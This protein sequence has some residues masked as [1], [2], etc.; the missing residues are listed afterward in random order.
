M[1]WLLVILAAI[2]GFA[3]IYRFAPAFGN[4]ILF[5]LFV[6]AFAWLALNMLNQ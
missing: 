3:V 2:F 1:D 6:M 5:V 4:T